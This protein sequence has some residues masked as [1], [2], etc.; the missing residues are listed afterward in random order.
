M[1]VFNSWTPCSNIV[2]SYW[3]RSELIDSLIK[4]ASTSLSVVTAEDMQDEANFA[5]KSAILEHS[6]VLYSK[7]Q[8]KCLKD[9]H[10][11]ENG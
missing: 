10:A 5:L 3:W 8:G 6:L 4:V 2:A 7:Y 1:I 11:C 9:F